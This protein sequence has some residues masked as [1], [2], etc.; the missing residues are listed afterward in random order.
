MTTIRGAMFG[1]ALLPPRRYCEYVPS[2]EPVRDRPLPGDWFVS[3]GWYYLGSEGHI[4]PLGLQELKRTLA[5]FRNGK[6]V[7]VWREGFSGWE[8]AGDVPE[9]RARTSLPPSQTGSQR[10]GAAN[11]KLPLWDTI[12]LSYSS[13]FHNFTDVLRISWL[14]L[15][16]VTPLCGIMNWV[17]FSLMAD[18]IASMKRGMPASKPIETTVLSNVAYLVFIFAGVSIAVAWHR[19]IVLGE[20]PGF[21][22]SNLA[23]KSLW[24]YLG[25]GIVIGLIVLLPA[26]LLSLPMFVL[27]SPVV[28]GGAPR[29]P[30]LIPVIFLVY[31]AAFAVF[32]RLSLLLPA[33]AIGDLHLTFKETWK[34][35]RGNTWRMFWGT[36]AC[37][38]LPILAAQIVLV[39]S[40]GPGMSAIEAFAS[41]M[42]FIVTILFVYHLLTLPIAIGFLSYSYRHFFGRT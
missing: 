12:R 6:D 34:R 22:G 4:G 36:A 15:A 40:L 33:R 31:L 5:G 25:M 35:T 10:D 30:M 14:W 7:L 1:L 28:A 17:Q 41:R 3:D 16:V 8:R 38:W 29:F 2:F 11:P 18:V 19:R 24:R 9:L 39:G 21:S 32:L 13:Y 26:L 37:A 27:L 20:H 23:T 42:A